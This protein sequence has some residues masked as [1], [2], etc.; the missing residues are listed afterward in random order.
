MSRSGP[1]S[2]TFILCEIAKRKFGVAAFDDC[3]ILCCDYRR[4]G[5]AAEPYDDS[6]R[7]MMMKVLSGLAAGVA[8]R[9]FSGDGRAPGRARVCLYDTSAVWR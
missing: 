7:E 9:L 2:M 3:H 6:G 8:R 4:F 1:C 5:C